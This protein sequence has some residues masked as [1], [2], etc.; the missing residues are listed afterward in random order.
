MK[1]VAFIV[2]LGAL[3]S[4]LAAAPA[5]AEVWIDNTPKDY[6]SPQRFA[7]E[8]KGGAYSPDIDS[9]PGLTGTPFADLF[10]DQTKLVVDGKV[11]RP[12]PKP[13]FAI[14]LD[15][16]FWHGFGSLGV[17]AS[18]GFMR[19]TTHAF[20]YPNDDNTK[21]CTAG[22]DDNGILGCERSGDTTALNIMPLT[23]ELVYRFDVLA[24][25]YRIPVVPYLKGGLAYYFWFV[26]RGDSGLAEAKIPGGTTQ[27]IGGTAGLVAH[28]GVSIM[29]DAI[30]KRAGE[31]LDSE[32][33]INHV[34]VFAELNYA[35]I[36]GLG[37]KNKMVLSDM[38]WT[39]GMAFE[40]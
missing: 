30:D 6:R 1:R 32:L 29:L 28:P 26:Q 33:G 37:F 4:S 40:F 16:Q 7:L 11:Q 31:V 27:G 36:N 39:V 21:P 9:T 15:W 24:L 3:A 25:K 19:R 14:E 18:V 20:R 35:W 10:N 2:T 13:L 38:N 5:R 8:L 34:H 23:L 12:A 17:G 22:V